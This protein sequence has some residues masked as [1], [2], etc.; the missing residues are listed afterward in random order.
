[1]PSEIGEVLSRLTGYPTMNLGTMAPRSEVL[2][3]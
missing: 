3:M 1:M 2:K